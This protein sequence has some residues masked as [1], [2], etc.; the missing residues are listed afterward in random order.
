MS[1]GLGTYGVTPPEHPGRGGTSTEE[2]MT[3]LN[4][5]IARLEAMRPILGDAAV[6]AAIAALRA[7]TDAAVVQRMVAQTITNAEQTVI[8]GD[9]HIHAAPLDPALAREERAV[10][11]WLGRVGRACNVVPLAQIDAAHADQRPL[12]LGH[13]YIGLNTVTQVP[14]TPEEIARL[15]AAQRPSGDRP[16]RPLAALEA[17][18]LAHHGRLLLLGAPGSGKSTFTLHLAYRL[19]T[20]ALAARAIAATAPTPPPVTDLPGWH[21]GPLLPVR[22]VL[23][24]LAAFTPLHDA[25]C[26]TAG[27]LC[28]F[29]AD[30]LAGLGYADARA[31]L[32]DALRGGGAVLLLD[33]LDEVVGSPMLARVVETI[34][35]S[36]T[37]FGACPILVTCRVLDYQ[38]EPMRQLPG[39]PTQTLA[40]LSDPQ[41]AAFIDGWY[42]ELS[43]SGRGDPA[44]VRTA[45][46]ALQR[47]I[48][49]RP[50]LRALAR[51]PL[52]LT[53]MA[54]VHASKGELP[55]ARALLYKECIDLL[56]LRWRQP[57]GAPDL[58][59]QLGL[60]QFR[61][62]DLLALMAR[63]GF[64]AHEQA[65]PEATTPRPTDLTEGQ[66]IALLAEEFRR[67]DSAH[68]YALAQTVLDALAER[69][70]LLLKHGPHRYSFPHRTFQEFLAGYHL[71]GQQRDYHKLCVERARQPQWHEALT[72]M[73]GYQVLE[74]REL[75]RPL[76]LV[77]KLLGCGPLE[78]ALGGE[79]LAQIGAER[80]ASY[81]PAM[82]ATDGLWARTGAVLRRLVTTGHAP[83]VAAPLRARAGLALGQ[84][85][86]G[87]L[88]QR[89][90]GV[91]P[92]HADPRLLDPATGDAPDGRY[93]CPVGAGTFW[94][95]D[96][97][98]GKLT[99]MTLA[100][101]FRI[102]RYPV[103]NAEFAAFI[104][105]GGYERQEWWTDAGWKF[106]Q[107]GGHL[108]ED[109]EQRITLPR[110]WDDP[111][112]NN[113]LQP[114]VGVSWYEAAAYSRW[115][116]AQGHVAR[117]L[118][119]DDAI[120]LP[121][122]LE[123][124]CAAR[125]QDNQRRYPWGND[126]P[127]PERANYDQTQ[128]GTSTPIGCFPTGAAAC[129][130]EDLAGNVWEWMATSNERPQ[131]A[132]PEKDFTPNEGV[133]VSGSAFWREEAQLCCGSRIGY[134]PDVG[135]Y[136]WSF[137]VIWP[138]RASE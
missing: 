59:T 65:T 81:D 24:E 35:A 43:A 114:V 33:G 125:G 115:L 103:T 13:V 130:A 27:L 30:Q 92:T 116:T 25:P 53:V 84:L 88:G 66:V 80:A 98:K 123:W 5:K 17:L 76:D 23:R 21:R 85:C 94:Y 41:I 40:D 107:P 3:D 36:V 8:Y 54:L 69:N 90:R 4:D 111:N 51:L 44:Q 20:A 52:L 63:M 136:S 19:A 129:G 39:F 104:A 9:Q 89:G 58:L 1:P 109:Q 93:W 82:L 119:P 28:A 118:L 73:V 96:D 110:Y 47:A 131:Q 26:G 34:I 99:Q 108:Y 91:A 61:S 121:T 106:L 127:T 60:S 79:L 6:D 75:E 134:N 77:S 16:T 12:E 50:E 128:I 100:Y 7:E 101:T 45:S 42:A 29:L 105:A 22:V 70:G 56:L 57:H 112:F 67:Y 132:T 120:R 15:P 102:A 49:A 31:P 14:L 37:S 86:Y 95:G 18:D 117:W 2:P 138:E 71:K 78:Q 87:D 126:A 133:L 137:R 62:S 74:D 72:L 55:D 10:R 11:G 64:A 113:P 122:S 83:D 48:A 124:E 32:E 97:Q 68:R 46:A 38:V 135:D